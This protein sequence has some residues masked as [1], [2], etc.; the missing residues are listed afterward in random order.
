MISIHAA[1]EDELEEIVALDL[2]LGLGRECPPS[3]DTD[4]WGAW[5][6]SELVGYAGGRLIDT[7]AYYL[8]RAGVVPEYRGR[9]LQKRLIRVRVARARKLGA[10]RVVTYTNPI[11]AASNNSLIACGF[12]TTKPWET[13]TSE[14]LHWRKVLA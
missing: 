13:A 12:K 2:S 5:D 4:W 9:G 6:G 1:R 14:W 8:S 7:G 3:A 11:N 10:P